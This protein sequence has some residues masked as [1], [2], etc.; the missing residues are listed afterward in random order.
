MKYGS[1][2]HIS[3]VKYVMAKCQAYLKNDPAHRKAASWTKRIAEYEETLKD[4]PRGKVA[5]P[6]TSVDVPAGT[7][8]GGA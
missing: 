7:L 1:E 4:I 5:S 2:K 3:N 8:K 6:G